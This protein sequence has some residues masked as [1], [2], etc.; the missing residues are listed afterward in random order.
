MEKQHESYKTQPQDK[1]E[2]WYEM[3]HHP[4][5]ARCCICFMP[6]PRPVEDGM[7]YRYQ[8]SMLW[9]RNC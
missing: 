9:T 5:E 4:P 7:L 2:Y 3:P 1:Y 8:E 6:H